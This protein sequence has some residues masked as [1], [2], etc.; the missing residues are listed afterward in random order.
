MEIGQILSAK[1]SLYVVVFVQRL[2]WPMGRA[3]NI[4]GSFLYYVITEVIWCL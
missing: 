4:N 1:S 2:I 3:W